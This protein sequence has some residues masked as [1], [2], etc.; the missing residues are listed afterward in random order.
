MICTVDE[1]CIYKLLLGNFVTQLVVFILEIIY[2]IASSSR[3][4][5]PCNPVRPSRCACVHVVAAVLIPH[6]AVVGV[7]SIVDSDR[8]VLLLIHW[9]QSSS[10]IPRFQGV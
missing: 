7:G 2:V 6:L 1:A 8:I 4:V 3:V 9:T 5:T 10:V